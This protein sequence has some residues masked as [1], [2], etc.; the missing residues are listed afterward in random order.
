TRP[1][2]AEMQLGAFPPT[3][4]RGLNHRIDVEDLSTVQLQLENGVFATYAQCHYT[5]DYW[6]NYTVI[7]TEGRMEN[8]GNG[9]AG[10]HVRV[11]N[12]RKP[13]YDARGDLTCRIPVS[14]GAH[15]GADPLI[16]AEFLRFA[17]HGGRTATSPLAARE[18]VATGCMATESLRAGGALR[19]VP[20]VP[21]G[22]AAHYRA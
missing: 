14:R 5:P 9:E 16:M 6:R 4:L 8:F 20:R 19:T 12:R 18:S 15:G 10:T 1:R 21:A 17:R 11:W 13:G 3:R 7:G 22:L 2:P